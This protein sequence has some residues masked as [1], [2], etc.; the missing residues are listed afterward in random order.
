M[1]LLAGFLTLLCLVLATLLVKAYRDV[2]RAIDEGEERVD[3][4]TRQR[5]DPATARSEIGRR[6]R[7]LLDEV[8][9]D[10]REKRSIGAIAAGSMTHDFRTPIARI[11]S[12]IEAALRDPD[13][14]KV[15]VLEYTLEQLRQHQRVFDRL[16]TFVKLDAPGAKLPQTE[17][18]LSDLVALLAED[19]EALFEDEGTELKSVIEPGIVIDGNREMLQLT[20]VNLFENIRKYAG[21]SDQVELSLRRYGRH[22]SLTVRD[23]GPGLPDNM[24]Q[25]NQRFWQEKKEGAKGFGLGLALVQ[26]IT[27]LHDGQLELTNAQPG[28][29]V[30]IRIPLKA[31]AIDGRLATT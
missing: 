1:A 14:D 3:A 16:L 22:C 31:D 8:L 21:D 30:T 18:D 11:S 12:R 9:A 23:F 29:L 4:G 2:N 6:V 25:A 24:H 20:L 28:L 10:G 15:D 5:L 13:L 26:E 7:V 19:Y 17:T 27:T